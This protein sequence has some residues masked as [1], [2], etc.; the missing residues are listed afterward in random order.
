ML[1]LICGYPRAGK[2][3]YSERFDCPVVHLDECHTHARVLDKIRRVD[4]DIVVDGIYYRPQHRRELI[5]AYGGKDTRCIF[6]DTPREVRE[7]RMG[8]EIRH[9]YPFPV[10]M[11][12][13]GWD[14]IIVIGGEGDESICR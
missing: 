10:P 3:T 1:T 12:D 5:G 7:K 11:L 4:G 14:E 8:H 9:E 13:E 2:T 6:L